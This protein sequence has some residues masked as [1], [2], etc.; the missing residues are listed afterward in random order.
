VHA[1]LEIPTAEQPRIDAYFN[2]APDAADDLVA[3]PFW[4]SD[5]Q[6]G[7]RSRAM[8][9]TITRLRELNRAGLRVDVVAFDPAPPSGDRDAYLAESLAEQRK[10][11]PTA[12]IIVL[13]GNL[14][15][16]RDVRAR[17][18][19]DHAFMAQRLATTEPSLTTLNVVYPGGTAW[20]CTGSTPE[21]CAEHSMGSRAVDPGAGIRVD[22]ADAGRAYDGTFAVG[23]LHASPPAVRR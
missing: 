12:R 1:A 3:G 14:H 5:Y 10:L 9:A 19:G 6:D 17:A 7:R 21:S 8:L 16:R 15:A 4:T 11:D 23:A 18:D 2:S 20:T 13:T 22:A